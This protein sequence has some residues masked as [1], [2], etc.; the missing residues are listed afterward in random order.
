MVKDLCGLSVFRVSRACNAGPLTHAAAPQSVSPLSLSC[1]GVFTR[2]APSTRC[3]PGADRAPILRCPNSPLRSP[4][5]H[6]C[7]APLTHLA[8]RRIRRGR[9]VSLQTENPRVF[10][11]GGF[12]FRAFENAD[13][14]GRPCSDLL[15]QALRLSTIGAEEFDGRVRD[16]IGSWAPRKNHKVSEKHLV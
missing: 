9:E 13:V 6:H 1:G 3:H 11:R 16:G 7:N 4:D 14:F 2:T 5:E 15:S 12:V 8:A 10:R